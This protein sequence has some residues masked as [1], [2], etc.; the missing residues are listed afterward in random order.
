MSACG[1]KVYCGVRAGHKL[2]SLGSISAFAILLWGHTHKHSN[3]FTYFLYDVPRFWPR[4]TLPL[5][6]Y[7]P[8]TNYLHTLDTTNNCSFDAQHITSGS[9]IA[10]ALGKIL[11]SGW[12]NIICGVLRIWV[13]GDGIEKESASVSRQ[14]DIGEEDSWCLEW[15]VN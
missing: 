11:G 5:Q 1:D 10:A 4:Y 15:R 3:P 14:K 9:S 6:I 8:L 13:D 2:P 7:T 12:D